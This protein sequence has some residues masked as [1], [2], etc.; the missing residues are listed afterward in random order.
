MCL[1]VLRPE[2]NILLGIKREEE[3]VAKAHALIGEYPDVF[4]TPVDVAIDKDG[5]RIEM[6]VRDLQTRR[7]DL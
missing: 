5:Q 7:Q 6:D 2:S 1:C 4:S 3:V